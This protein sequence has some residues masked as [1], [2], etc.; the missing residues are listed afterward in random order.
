VTNYTAAAKP[1][2]RRGDKTI[3]LILNTKAYNEVPFRGPDNFPIAIGRDRGKKAEIESN[4]A[5][6]VSK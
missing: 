1:K 5:L 4:L 3:H 6:L 2:R